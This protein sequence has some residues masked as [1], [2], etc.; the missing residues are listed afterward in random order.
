MPTCRRAALRYV[1][2][3]TTHSCRTHAANGAARPGRRCRLPPALPH[4]QPVIH[5]PPAS[6]RE[7]GGARPSPLPLQAARHVPKTWLGRGG[8]VASSLVQLHIEFYRSTDL[9]RASNVVVRLSCSLIAPWHVRE[10][11]NRSRTF[12]REYLLKYVY[13]YSVCLQLRVMHQ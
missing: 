8:A 3:G 6:R 7:G 1:S 12:Q 9:H 11:G 5:P 10:T 13:R 4:H 2:P